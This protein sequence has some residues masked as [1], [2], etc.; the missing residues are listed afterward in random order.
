MAAPSF[1]RKLYAYLYLSFCGFLFVLRKIFPFGKKNGYRTFLA[2][3]EQEGLPKFS[4]EFREL[5]S[6]AG[7]CIACGQCDAACPEL[8]NRDG[9]I[10]IGP[11]HLVMSS[12]RGGPLLA[13]SELDLQTI[14]SE[15]C[16]SCQKCEQACPR[17]IPIISLA[18][19]FHAQLAIPSPL[20]GEG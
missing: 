10:F 17:N 19:G 6:R 18:R 2:N 16:A 1:A 7:D 15:Q 3:Y 11:M 13:P 4:P 20:R 12:F 5:A 8:T 9:G 14:I